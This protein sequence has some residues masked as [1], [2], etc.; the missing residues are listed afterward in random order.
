MKAMQF[1][2]ALL[3][4]WIFRIYIV[5]LEANYLRRTSACKR[6]FCAKKAIK[7]RVKWAFHLKKNDAIINEI[8]VEV[9]RCYASN[10]MPYI[11]F[12]N[13]KMLTIT[14]SIVNYLSE[15]RKYSFRCEHKLKSATRLLQVSSTSSVIPVVLTNFLVLIEKAV[16]LFTQKFSS[17]L[18]NKVNNNF[19]AFGFLPFTSWLKRIRTSSLKKK[20]LAGGLKLYRGK[21]Q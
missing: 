13:L 10:C 1:L 8:L 15:N 21:Q 9:L 3:F 17:I 19:L 6:F 5:F 11:V 2:K 7:L 12:H 14:G 20:P 16:N 4:S 18:E